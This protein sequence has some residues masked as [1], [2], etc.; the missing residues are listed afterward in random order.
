MHCNNEWLNPT[1][2]RHPNSQWS[3]PLNLF[4]NTAPAVCILPG[5]G[6]CCMCRQHQCWGFQGIFSKITV[7]IRCVPSAGRR[8]AVLV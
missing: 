1:K 2:P 7:E 6:G 4:P 8:S 3:Y 5:A